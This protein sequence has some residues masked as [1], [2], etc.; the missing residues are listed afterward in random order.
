MQCAIS[1]WKSASKEQGL[2]WGHSRVTMCF[3]Q[4]V[5]K[6]HKE[7]LSSYPIIISKK[8][9]VTCVNDLINW[10]TV[11]LFSIYSEEL[12]LWVWLLGCEKASKT[13]TKKFVL[14]SSSVISFSFRSQ[15]SQEKELD[16]GGGWCSWKTYDALHWILSCSR[17]GCLRFVPQIWA[18]SPKME[19]LAGY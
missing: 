5:A 15:T 17:K 16:E 2:C 14:L 7:K 3:R 18:G 13:W 19:G 12:H 8:W 6:W 11:L 1:E 4:L 10:N 9:W